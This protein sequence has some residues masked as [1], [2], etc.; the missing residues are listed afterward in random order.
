MAAIDIAKIILASE[1]REIPQNY[2]DT[3]KVF[4]ALYIGLSEDEAEKFAQFA[5][6]RNI[7]PHEYFD[8]RWKGIKNFVKES[9]KFYPQFIKGVKKIIS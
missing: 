9:E 2:K 5:K 1:K 8:I 6:L 3:L 4:T 7:V